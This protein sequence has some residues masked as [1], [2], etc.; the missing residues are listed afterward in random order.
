MGKVGMNPS[1]SPLIRFNLIAKASNVAVSRL[2]VAGC[3]CNCSVKLPSAHSYAPLIDHADGGWRA[4][5]IGE[6]V[7]ARAFLNVDAQWG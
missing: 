4:L 1:L 2:V 6:C 7:G 5:S 3:E